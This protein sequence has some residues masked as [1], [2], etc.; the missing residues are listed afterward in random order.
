MAW[1][2]SHSDEAYRNA[3]ANVHKLP[4]YKLIEILREWAYADREEAGKKPSFRLTFNARAMSQEELADK[5]WRRA[6]E[7][8]LC[9]NGGWAAY[10]CPE[11]C[12]TVSFDNEDEEEEMD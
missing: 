12:H 3:E 9:T 11:G 5:V 7:L 10:I 2:W 4:K 8:A 1:E 6:D